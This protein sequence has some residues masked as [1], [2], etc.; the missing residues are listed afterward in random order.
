MTQEVALVV[1]G[2]WDTVAKNIAAGS[3]AVVAAAG[4]TQATATPIVSSLSN[5]TTVG[6]GSGVI[7][8]A[9]SGAARMVVFNNQATNALLVYPP[10]GGTIGAGAANAGFS[11]PANK[12]V[13][14]VTADGVF[15]IPALSA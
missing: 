7:L 12:A 1:G 4:T 11:V 3:L 14:L 5:V 13:W 9:G 8:P 2:I 15:W 6:A 10:L